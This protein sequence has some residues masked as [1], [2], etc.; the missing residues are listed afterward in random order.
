MIR[1]AADWIDR[2]RGER[3]LV[4]GVQ[5]LQGSGKTTLCAQLETTVQ[6]CVSVSLDDFYLPDD[7]IDQTHDDPRLRGRGNPG[8]HDLRLLHDCVDRVKRRRPVSF[9]V[10][11][12]NANGGRGD[13]SRETRHAEEVDVLILEGWCLGFRPCHNGD[14]VDAHL[15][16]YQPIFD[17]FD[18]MIILEADLANLRPWRTQAEATMTFDETRAFIDRFIPTF[19]RRPRTR[20]DHLRAG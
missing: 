1:K 10:Y 20:C 12:K 11:D 5:G 18:A 14:L 7:A 3:P 17:A 16:A 13:R 2:L 19:Y 6:G 4:I 15:K 8:T 9:P